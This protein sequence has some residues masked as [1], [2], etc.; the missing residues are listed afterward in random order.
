[1]DTR[2][3]LFTYHDITLHYGLS[4]L[5]FPQPSD[6]FPSTNNT[7]GANFRPAPSLLLHVLS[8]STPER[9]RR[10]AAYVAA[11][12][13][14]MNT[15]FTPASWHLRSPQQWEAALSRTRP[16]LPSAGDLGGRRGG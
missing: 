13:P 16:Y 2:D 14:T 4:R 1:M 7:C 10:P 5:T 9:T 8:S 6:P 3:A 11:Q 15:Y 12:S